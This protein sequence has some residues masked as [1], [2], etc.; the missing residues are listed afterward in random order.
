VGRSTLSVC[1]EREAAIAGTLLFVHGTGVRK[2][3]YERNL[4]RIRVGCANEGL[5]AITLEGVPWGDEVGISTELVE[6]TLPAAAARAAIGG[7]TP[8]DEAAAKWAILLEDPLF[9]LRIAAEGTKPPTGGIRVGSIAPEQELVD[10]VGSVASA[11]ASLDLGPAGISAEELSEAAT[12]VAGSEELAAAAAAAAVSDAARPEF[13]DA[14]ARA[15]VA[16]VL[17]AYRASPP[18]EAP[19][20]A[21]SA[22]IRDDLVDQIANLIAPATT[23]GVGAW[24]GK[25]VGR[26]VAPVATSVIEAR[27]TRISVGSMPF[28]GDILHYQKRGE[29]IRKMVREA[30]DGVS[31]R[32][33]VVLGHSLGGIV[34]VDLLTQEQAP[35]VEALVTVG[36]QS[37][38]FY[39]IDALDRIRRHEAGPEPAPFAP[40]LNIYDRADILSFVAGRVF[41]GIKKIQDEEIASGVPFPSAHSAYFHQP[42]VFQLIRAFWPK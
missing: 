12:A 28:L 26:F 21:Y 6:E 22:P 14:A 33:L 24:L 29:D 27:R 20:L 40:W 8:E 16:Q 1:R 23:R 2:T 41:P 25:R 3:G 13:A 37:P 38:L 5:G 39:A 15:I 19:P 7:P 18:D 35:K 31:Q 36:S 32:P 42:K 4:E 9:E 34:L 30:I 17:A 10:A 11:T